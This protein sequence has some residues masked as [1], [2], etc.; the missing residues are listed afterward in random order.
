MTE[1]MSVLDITNMR[2]VEFFE[3]LFVFHF[4]FH[5]HVRVDKSLHSSGGSW[6]ASKV[7]RNQRDKE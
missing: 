4:I 3:E 1:E 2:K 5:V 7:G 6:L